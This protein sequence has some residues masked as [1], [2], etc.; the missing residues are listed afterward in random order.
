MTAASADRLRRQWGH[1][2]PDQEGHRD[3]DHF[4]AIGH[5]QERIAAEH[6]KNPPPCRVISELSMAAQDADLLTSFGR[7]HRPH[8]GGLTDNTSHEI[9]AGR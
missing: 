6:T 1:A 5:T 4:N 2:N 9:D 8:K 3:H 7:V